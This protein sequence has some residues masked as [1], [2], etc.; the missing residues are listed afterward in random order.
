M[1]SDRCFLSAQSRSKYTIFH[2]TKDIGNSWDKDTGEDMIRQ[3]KDAKRKDGIIHLR[4]W[5]PIILCQLKARV[6]IL[7][8]Y[9]T[10]DS[11]D[12]WG[13]KY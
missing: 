7:H 6:S 1:T 2:Y 12:N 4:R 3:E 5:R 10:T 13:K 9:Y 11:G 8:Y